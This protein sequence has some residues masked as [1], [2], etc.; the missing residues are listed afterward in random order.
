MEGIWRWK[1]FWILG[2]VAGAGLC[3]CPDTGHRGRHAGLPLHL[4]VSPGIISLL[5]KLNSIGIL[6]SNPGI[7]GTIGMREIKGLN[8]DV[9]NM[10]MSVNDIP[11]K[12]CL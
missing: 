5:Q 2:A 10:W 3:V 1:I 4:F 9:T 6:K 7:G 11:E 8:T 12:R